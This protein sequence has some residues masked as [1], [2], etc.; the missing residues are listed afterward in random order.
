MSPLLMPGVP[1]G[2]SIGEK[3]TIPTN[4]VGIMLGNTVPIDTYLLS[5][6]MGGSPY[7][8]DVMTSMGSRL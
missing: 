4:F 6:L 8:P 7:V 3:P 2:F 1:G 5:G